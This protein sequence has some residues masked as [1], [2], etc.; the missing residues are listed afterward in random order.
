MSAKPDIPFWANWSTGWYGMGMIYE[1]NQHLWWHNG[2]L[3]GTV[4]LIAHTED[5]YTWA[6]L[7]NLRP[8]DF[9][10]FTDDLRA[11]TYSAVHSGSGDSTTDLY[12]RYPSPD[13]GP[14]R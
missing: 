9:G 3:P 6:M 4:A 13:L 2:S 8:D 14:L 10:R 5:G 12:S 11:T 7:A 1:T